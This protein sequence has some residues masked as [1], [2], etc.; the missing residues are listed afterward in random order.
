LVSFL[1]VLPSENQYVFEFRDPSWWNDAVYDLL[2]YKRVAFCIFDLSGVLSPV[3][4]TADFIYIRLHGPK[5]SYQGFYSEEELRKWAGRINQWEK[6]QK[7]VYCFFNNNQTGF[8][9]KNVLRL[10]EILSK[11]LGNEFQCIIQV[12]THFLEENRKIENING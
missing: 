1:K 2:K 5:Y 6:E 11:S 9:A 4:S 3:I 8:A 12:L 10:E 7:S